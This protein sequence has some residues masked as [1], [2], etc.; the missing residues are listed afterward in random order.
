MYRLKSIVPFALSI[1]FLMCLSDTAFGQPTL[2]ITDA[3]NQP[4]PNNTMTF[5]VG[6]SAS[7]TQSFVVT[8]NQFT[9]VTVTILGPNNGPAPTWLRFG[10]NQ[11]TLPGINLTPSSGPIALTANAANGSQGPLSPG[12]YTATVSVSVPGSTTV[13]LNIVL[14][15]GGT[16]ALTASPNSINC[17]AAQG[18]GTATCSAT[19]VAV[20]ATSATTYS[21][22]IAYQGQSL[23]WLGVTPQSNIPTGQS[24]S[25]NVNPAG[26]G[27]G[28]YNAVITAT[29]ANGID[30]AAVNVALTIS[31]SSAF[32][33]TPSNPPPFLY[34]VGGTLPAPI[35]FT[36]SSSTFQSFSISI[37][38][39]PW[40]STNTFGGFVGPNQDA[41]FT[42]TAQ[43]SGL[44]VGVTSGTVTLQP[45]SQGSNIA[46]PVSIVVS[47][48][49]L[50]Q[51][52]PT[53]LT[54]SAPFGGQPPAS[55]T[56]NITASGVGNPI[57][58]TF[59]SSD[60]S[61][62]TASVNQAVTPATMTVS[63]A[64][65]SLAVG[66]YNGT[67]TLQPANGDNYS[68][69]VNVTLTVGITQ[70]LTVGPPVMLF[71]FQ[72]TRTLPAPQ[73]A[74][75]SSTGQQVSFT[76]TAQP[77]TCTGQQ[78]LQ[79]TPATGVTPAQISVQVNNTIPQNPGV[80]TGVVT[81]TPSSGNPIQLPV[82]VTISTGA[83]LTIAMPSGFGY[84]TAPQGSS[85]IITRFLSVGSTD[86]SVLPFTVTPSI[87]SGSTAWLFASASGPTVT[88]LFNPA[89]L[90]VGV[91]TGNIIINNSTLPE[92][93]GKFTIPVT[94]TITSSTTVT[95]SPSQLT[96]TQAQGG[97]LPDSQTLTLSNSGGSP[98]FTAQVSPDV[99]KTL[100][101]LSPASGAA[102]GK[103][104]VSM[105]QN[106]ASV[107]T[108]NCQINF[109]FQN[110]ATQ[111]ATVPVTVNIT[112]PRTLSVSPTSLAFAYQITQAQPASQKIT[113]SST[114]GAVQFS[115]AAT[116]T[117]TGWLSVDTSSG[118]TPKDVNV[119]VNPTGLTAGTYN[120]Q[121]SISAPG[122]L[123]T[124]LVVPV[125]FTVSPA[126][127]PQ[128][129]T[130]TN[131][132][133]NA[134]GAISPGELVTIKGTLLGPT[135]GVSFSLNAQ[136]G[137]NA[138]L[139]G[140]RVLFSGIPGT[141]IYV[142][143]KQINVVVPW[144]IAFRTTTDV[145]VEYQGVSSAPVL[146][147]R[148][149]ESS[150][151]LF[152]LN[153]TGQGQVAALNQNGT[154]NGPG[155]SGTVPAPADTTVVVY[156]TGG[157]VTSPPGTTGSVSPTN[158]LLYL[159]GFFA[160]PKTITAT[161]AGLPARVEFAGAAPG[162]VSGVNQFNIHIPPGTPSG[163]QQIVITISGISSP[164]G[165]TI[166]VQ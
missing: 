98:T 11:T 74:T 114:G 10:G 106:N 24:F 58:F 101:S 78:W 4:F 60:P 47:N 68:I 113:L 17:S 28:T 43:P 77:T 160:T 99:C 157:G 156:A 9:T 15:V 31:G 82:T 84:E 129:L 96:F 81:I 30:T 166:A 132:A 48:N 91:Y 56:V 155:V 85:S 19:S 6:V 127:A 150:L 8:S 65:G 90:P 59:S 66:T 138:T 143:D 54:F 144:E 149:A 21:L 87:N 13:L 112:Q 111:S 137:V 117:P 72:T 107:Q 164:F 119:S 71:S 110:A 147:V 89:G 151:G 135:T 86:G 50:L 29:A 131:T 53:Q 38:N 116:S 94:L 42:L 154:F 97:P 121:I 165:A 22:A 2:T 46:I 63:V 69:K 23:S 105:L 55:Q 123:T 57:P 79:V 153:Q 83:L 52:S 115:V 64:Q 67:I 163:N 35:T 146:G 104:T 61:W 92:T 18:A 136:G 95:V 14:N 3:N 51:A 126:P 133:S 27:A 108:F 80:C 109:S 148:V 118:T 70:G 100:L 1:V 16:A 73:T 7:G 37:Q 124:P 130:I 122:V 141:P 33:V 45:F 76:A 40:L 152:T 134:P 32:T 20:N 34:Q 41:T 25:I 125:T 44:P 159:P 93:G 120:G 162:L 49:P 128:P 36:V 140:V 103:V 139:A 158:Q 39:A 5:N 161:V 75:V 26:L 142:S 12:Q 62:L 145:V 88:V 102:T